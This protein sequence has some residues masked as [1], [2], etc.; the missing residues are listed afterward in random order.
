MLPK[1]NTMNTYTHILL[2]LECYL[3]SIRSSSSSS[4]TWMLSLFFLYRWL[5]L[6]VIWK[7]SYNGWLVHL[8]EK[9]N[10]YFISCLSLKKKSWWW[11][12]NFCFQLD[13]FSHFTHEFLFWF[14]FGCIFFPCRPIKIRFDFKKF[15][16]SK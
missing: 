6:N 10:S 9:W 13:F 1:C 5:H 7:L 2:L 8:A 16:F 4:S 12:Y 11:P 14:C 3:N 15:F